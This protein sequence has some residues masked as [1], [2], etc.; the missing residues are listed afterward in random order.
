[1]KVFMIATRSVI[2]KVYEAVSEV[3]AEYSGEKRAGYRKGES[4]GTE[5]V[6]LDAPQSVRH[7]SKV[8]IRGAG[9]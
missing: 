1:M 8:A 5:G 9:P 6:I 7:S 4:W 2:S 3:D